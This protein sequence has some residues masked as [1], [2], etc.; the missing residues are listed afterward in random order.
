M[1]NTP[2]NE[3]LLISFAPLCQEKVAYNKKIFEVNKVNLGLPQDAFTD[4]PS[5]WQVEKALSPHSKSRCRGRART[6]GFGPSQVET[7][8]W[9]G[10][11]M[12]RIALPSSGRGI[13]F[14]LPRAGGHAGEALER[15]RSLSRP[16]IS[17]KM[18]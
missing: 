9:P 14:S 4:A 16:S 1:H 8:L 17:L 10:S 15:H 12:I 3:E 18:L 11:R 13:H 2:L 7:Y 5:A 6:E